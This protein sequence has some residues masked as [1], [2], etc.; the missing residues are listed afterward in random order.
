[1]TNTINCI[2]IVTFQKKKNT[3][4]KNNYLGK[5]AVID[6]NSKIKNSLIALKSYKYIL[7]K[8]VSVNVG[9]EIP[10][11]NYYSK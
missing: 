6:I 4:N 8:G 3:N 9:P 5:N 10:K 7:H 11:Q 2:K 1:M